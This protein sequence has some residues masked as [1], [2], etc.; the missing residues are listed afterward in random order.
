MRLSR[1][2]LFGV[3]AGLAFLFRPPPYT[4]FD[5]ESLPKLD[6]RIAEIHA[7]VLVRGLGVEDLLFTKEGEIFA[8][9]MKGDFVQFVNESF[10]HYNVLSKRFQVI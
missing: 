5:V 9:L 8:G 6:V 1:F 4:L 10:C 7:D 3:I 2:V